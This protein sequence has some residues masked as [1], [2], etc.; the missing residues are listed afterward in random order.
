MNIH[1]LVALLAIL[2]LELPSLA[3][4]STVFWPAS[5]TPER[6][7]I[8]GS[9]YFKSDVLTREIIFAVDERRLVLELLSSDEGRVS[10]DWESLVGRYYGSSGTN[11]ANDIRFFDQIPDPLPDDIANLQIAKAELKPIIWAFINTTKQIHPTNYTHWTVQTI[12]EYCALPTNFFEYTPSRNLSGNKAPTQKMEDD[13]KNYGWDSMKK[14]INLLTHTVGP[15][16]YFERE[17][18][19]ECNGSVAGTYKDTITYEACEN[20]KPPFLS[21]GIDWYYDDCSTYLGGL[22]YTNCSLYTSTTRKDGTLKGASAVRFGSESIKYIPAYSTNLLVNTK[23]YI[24]EILGSSGCESNYFR[25]VEV[26]QSNT[27]VCDEDII[28]F[29]G[30]VRPFSPLQPCDPSALSDPNSG[31]KVEAFDGSFIYSCNPDIS[32]PVDAGNANVIANSGVSAS[33]SY[34]AFVDWGFRFRN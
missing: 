4:W 18:G 11:D 19:I 25:A 13:G 23:S 5:G 29:Y 7:I 1:Y 31:V 17:R 30:Q 33:A 26:I 9:M 14:I 28:Y 3:Q 12:L 6:K 24:W 8:D 15:A 2:F 21:V 16:T 34:T 10:Q 20:P 22:A 27:Q 32:E